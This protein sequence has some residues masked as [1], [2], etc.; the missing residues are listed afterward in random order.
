M[1]TTQSDLTHIFSQY[2]NIN[3]AIL[4]LRDTRMKLSS[5]QSSPF[6]IKKLELISKR[7]RLAEVF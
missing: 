6:N 2:K 4:S 7:T 3:N 5:I 1:S